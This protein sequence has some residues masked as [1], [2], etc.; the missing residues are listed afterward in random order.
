MLIREKATYHPVLAQ[1][2]VIRA[3]ILRDIRT[4]FF[5]HGLGYLVAIAW[6]LVHI[7]ILLIIY[8]L[9]GRIAPH[10]DSTAL[11]FAT[12]LAPFMSFM[13]MARFIM[14]SLMMN[15]PLLQLPAVKITDL[16]FARAILEF[17]A[18]CCMIIVLM[19]IFYVSNVEV[20]PRD[21]SEAFYALGASMLMGLGF[22]IVNAILAVA[23]PGWVLAFTLFHITLYFTSGIVFSVDTMPEQFRYLLSF[24]P[25]FHGVEWMRYA[26]YQDYSAR[27]LDRF[28]MLSWAV[29]LLFFGL[30]IERV[31]RGRILQ[32]G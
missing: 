14:M 28:Y 24:N 19:T 18:S 21:T 12:G 11:F 27:E 4:R 32:G 25:M 1:F 3:I 16:L 20:I 22:G 7:L 15:R 26:F 17:F 5:G 9:T 31:V 23:I 29:G 13:Y 2:Q 8:Q 30:V 6:P 10:G